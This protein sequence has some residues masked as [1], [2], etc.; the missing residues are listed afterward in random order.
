M[1]VPVGA[2]FYTGIS[3]SSVLFPISSP[4]I[5]QWIEVLSIEGKTRYSLGAKKDQ[6]FCTISMMVFLNLKTTHFWGSTRR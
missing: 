3:S 5:R 4:K 6:V 2:P 1:L